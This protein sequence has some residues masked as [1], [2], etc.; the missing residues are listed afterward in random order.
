ML[1][2]FNDIGNQKICDYYKEFITN[3][4][5]TGRIIDVGQLHAEYLKIRD[6]E[7]QSD[8]LLMSQ[9]NNILVRLYAKVKLKIR[10]ILNHAARQFDQHEI[11]NFKSTYEARFSQQ[12]ICDFNQLALVVDIIDFSDTKNFSYEN[13]LD[14]LIQ[15]ESLMLMPL[16]RNPDEV[17]LEH[18]YASTYPDKYEIA[19]LRKIADSIALINAEDSRVLWRPILE[20]D[21][22]FY[23]WIDAFLS[24][25]FCSSIKTNITQFTIIWKEMI[26]FANNHW[27]VKSHDAQN[28]LLRLFGIYKREPFW[29]D[30]DFT[31]VIKELAPL[32]L[33]WA[34]SSIKE[35][36]NINNYIAF[37]SSIA[38]APL[39]KDNLRLVADALESSSLRDSEE[40]SSLSAQLCKEVWTNHQ[41]LIKENHDFADAFF[42]ILSKS[43]SLGS[44]EALDLQKEITRSNI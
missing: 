9:S 5:Y 18:N 43:I 44:S 42:R 32:Y 7:L 27:D 10:G 2:G 23:S 6:R 22:S 11:K 21:L 34:K 38:G 14:L 30:A 4:K 16:R 24:Y 26:A 41:Y 39:I 33:R 25:F 36:N 35:Y 29:I 15:I 37:C 20:L 12:P 31:P 28:L 1:H 3:T 8:L 13:Q 19:C 17:N 40:T